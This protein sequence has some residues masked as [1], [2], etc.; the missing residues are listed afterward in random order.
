MSIE[1]AA[2]REASHRFHD[3]RGDDDQDFVE[4]VGVPLFPRQQGQQALAEEGEAGDFDQ[5]A[6]GADQEKVE[7]HEHSRF[8]VT[9]RV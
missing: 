1:D 3:R 6:R 9:A 4:D 5:R 7:V 8:A 2:W